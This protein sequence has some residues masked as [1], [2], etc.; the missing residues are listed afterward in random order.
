MFGEGT[1]ILNSGPPGMMCKLDSPWL[2]PYLFVSL[3]RW[4]FGIRVQ[5]N[6]AL[7]RVYCLDLGGSPQVR[8]IAS[9]LPGPYRPELGYGTLFQSYITVPQ[10]G[11]GHA[12]THP[13]LMC[14]CAVPEAECYLAPLR[15]TVGCFPD[16]IELVTCPDLSPDF[17]LGFTRHPSPVGSHGLIQSIISK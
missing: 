14:V 10:C 11:I 12:T 16:D 15:D 2:C 5:G 13:P 17:A 1:L 7:I 9:S 6:L 3:G 4:P 8:K